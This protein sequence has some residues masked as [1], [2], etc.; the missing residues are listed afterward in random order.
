MD[1]SRKCNK[2]G[3]KKVS[4]SKIRLFRPTTVKGALMK[5][6]QLSQEQRYQIYA[7]LKIDVNLSE[8]AEVLKVH[9]STIC[10]EVR[11]N[12]GKRGYRPNQAHRKAMARAK[13]AKC[14]IRPEDWKLIEEKL[15]EEFSPEQVVHWV[16]KHYGLIVSHEWI[17]QHIWEVKKRHGTLYTYLRRQKKYR[18]RGGKCDN[19]GKIAHRRSIEDRPKIVEQRG[20]VGDWEADTIIGKGK[21]G[22]IVT[23]VDRKSRYLRMGK[24]SRRTKEL[25]A[26]KIISLLAGLP[27][28]TITC[29]NGKEFADHEKIATELQTDVFFAHPYSSW[30]RGTNENTNGLIRQYIPKDTYFHKLSTLD[31]VSVENR[32]NSR[33]RKCLDFDQ[34]VVFLKKHCC[35]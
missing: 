3:M 30:E 32:L 25:V 1:S 26:N 23:L 24:V 7:L 14:K 19:R 33:P 31:A 29:D 18:H 10:R 6:R 2:G 12:K 8:I 21:K 9:R 27:V 16:R 28:H 13:K 4:C 20:R 15:C 17:Y 11:R 35:T 34:P 5:Y 22:A